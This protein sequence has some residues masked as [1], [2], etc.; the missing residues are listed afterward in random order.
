MKFQYEH[1]RT[2][3]LVKVEIRDE[4]CRVIHK[5]QFNL[6]DKNAIYDL[7]KALEKFSNF[8]IY[9]IIKS[10]TEKGEWW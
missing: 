5:A 7:L 9:E 2:G 8:S 10:K 4:T 1:N 6:M 3:D